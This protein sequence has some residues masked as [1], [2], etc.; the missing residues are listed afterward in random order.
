MTWFICLARDLIRTETGERKPFWVKSITPEMLSVWHMTR[1]FLPKVN[2]VL[3]QS[4]TGK[5]ISQSPRFTNTGERLRLEPIWYDCWQASYR[6][7]R[8]HAYG[9]DYQGQSVWIIIQSVHIQLI[10]VNLQLDSFLSYPFLNYFRYDETVRMPC[11]SLICRNKIIQTLFWTK[12][13]SLISVF[14]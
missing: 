4:W 10:F 7:E 13:R 3:Y 12:S 5:H 2:L 11:R 6:Q 8:D 1:P 9:Q 14:Y